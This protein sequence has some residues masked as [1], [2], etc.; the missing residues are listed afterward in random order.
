MYRETMFYDEVQ[1]GGGGG[2][3]G[4]RM[5]ELEAFGGRATGLSV[6]PRD[7]GWVGRRELGNPVKKRTPLQ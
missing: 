5:K 6:A 7:G 4:R 1:E 2:G 3:G